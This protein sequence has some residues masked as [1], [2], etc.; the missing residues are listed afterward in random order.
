MVAAVN[1]KPGDMAIVIKAICPENVGTIV[2][3]IG[4][5]MLPH[6]KNGFEW[7]TYTPRPSPAFAPEL[8]MVTLKTHSDC[9]DAWLRPV[10]D[11][12]DYESINFKQP[13]TA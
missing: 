10:S 2:E 3:V 9:P 8:G 5:G 11:L 1:C 4:P 7:Q 13:V 12:P 6:G